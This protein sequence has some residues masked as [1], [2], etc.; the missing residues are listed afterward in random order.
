MSL[1]RTFISM[2]HCSCIHKLFNKQEIQVVDGK[3]RLFKTNTF[4]YSQDAQT[5]IK[6]LKCN[7][8]EIYFSYWDLYNKEYQIIQVDLY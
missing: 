1:A 5:Y 8:L 6:K 3:N 2:K 4:I 7:Q